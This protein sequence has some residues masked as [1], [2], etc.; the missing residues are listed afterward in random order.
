MFAS[1]R[2]RAEQC[3]G[4]VEF[5]LVQRGKSHPGIAVQEMAQSPACQQSVAAVDRN[6]LPD[7]FDQGSIPGRFIGRECHDHSRGKTV[8]RSAM[9]RFGRTFEQTFHRDR[10]PQLRF[11][12]MTVERGY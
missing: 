11:G 12:T 3:L 6:N 2:E 1:S 10:A 8:D 9:R 4:I 7:D 5:V